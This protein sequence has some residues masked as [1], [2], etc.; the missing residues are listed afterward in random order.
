MSS[1]KRGRNVQ[2]AGHSAHRI[3]GADS[4]GNSPIE[5][6]VHNTSARNNLRD[7]ISARR[8]RRPI[9]RNSVLGNSSR[10]KSV[11]DLENAS[12]RREIRR[13]NADRSSAHEGI[14]WPRM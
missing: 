8:N 14:N 6:Y 2:N 11:I 7:E 4:G 10:G 1:Q 5:E 12:Y 13:K 3:A 9:R